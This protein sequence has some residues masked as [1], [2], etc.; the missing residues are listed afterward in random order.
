V[1]HSSPSLAKLLLLHCSLTLAALCA[2]APRE[3]ILINDGWRFQKGDPVGLDAGKLLYDVRPES[4]NE[5]QKERL[6]EAVADAEKLARD[7]K[8]VLK[9]WILPSANPF[10]KD[11]AQRH[12][13]PPGNPGG[14]VAYVQPG[15]KGP[16]MAQSCGRFTGVQVESS[17][18]GWT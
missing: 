16:A 8:P 7:G 9:P 2:D 10:I 6:A 5:D 14:D 3:R 12:I 18:P 11:P 4:K 13:R 15:L 1:I 17:K